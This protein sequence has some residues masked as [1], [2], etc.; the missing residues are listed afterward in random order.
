MAD[1]G[2]IPR[3]ILTAEEHECEA[4]FI[5]THFR[6]PSGRYGVWLP[7]KNSDLISN[8][9]LSESYY[10][11]LRMLKVMEERF[12]R[13]PKLKLA[14]SDFMNEY[15]NLE[16]MVATKFTTVDN[17][18]FFLP[19]RGV[20]KE[21]STTT[22]LRTVFNGSARLKS[23]ISLNDLLIGQNLLPNL[24]DLVCRWRSYQYVFTA[25]MEKMYRQI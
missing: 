4:H 2:T 22:K 25:D 18:S 9:G 3:T 10:P 6:T 24:F 23:G 15:V 19:H 7:F 8:L 11:A 14:Y 16:H 17:H 20:W 13:D 21:S 12:K 1:G 5:A